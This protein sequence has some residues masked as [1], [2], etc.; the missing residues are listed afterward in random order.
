MKEKA[1]KLLALQEGISNN[2]AKELIDKGL[3]YAMIRHVQKLPVRRADEAVG[4]HHVADDAEQAL[5]IRG[6]F[7]LHAAWSLRRAF[8]EQ[9]T[10]IVVANFNRDVRL[11][12]LARGCAR[13]PLIVA[14][15][16]LPILHDNWRY[17]LTYRR[18]TA[19]IVTN[20][21]AIRSRYLGY[22]WI[23]A[24]FVRVI[25]NGIDPLLVDLARCQ[26][27]RE[28]PDLLLV[29][30]D[31]PG[32]PVDRKPTTD[33]M[34]D[35]IHA[36]ARIPL[37]EIRQ[38]PGGHVWGEE[39]AIAGGV[40]PNMIGHED[41]RM[42]VGHPEV[43]AEL[44]EVRAEPVFD[45]GGYEAGEN[46]DDGERGSGGKGTAQAAGGEERGQCGRQRVAGAYEGRVEH[47]ELLP[48]NDGLKDFRTLL[49]FV[50]ETHAGVFAKQL[51]HRQQL[52]IGMRVTLDGRVRQ[53][54]IDRQAK[55]L[56]GNCPGDRQVVRGR[57]R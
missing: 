8:A 38:Y 56:G 36:T 35:A 30:L 21:E 41:R 42:A 49:Y 33:E 28:R 1:Y 40:I 24:D 6:D 39:E 18:L 45:G 20:T 50:A 3:V 5:A 31:I 4:P 29:K 22:G 51:Q 10:E 54:R 34:L 7:N 15:N 25:H 47:L 2:K 16:G 11:A 52:A 26:P 43:I 14:R 55:N 46:C 32:I 19:G 37:D 48:A 12:A 57:R 13:R 44:R 27:A 17:R 23:P 9:G 53:R